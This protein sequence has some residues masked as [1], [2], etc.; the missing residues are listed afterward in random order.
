MKHIIGLLVIFVT[1]AAGG[2]AVEAEQAK[3]VPDRIPDWDLPFHYLRSHRGIP[4]GSAR[5]WVRGGEKHCH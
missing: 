3:K 1:L 4:A 5:A 2:V